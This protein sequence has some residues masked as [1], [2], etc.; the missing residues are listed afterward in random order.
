MRIRLRTAIPSSPAARSRPPTYESWLRSGRGK[1]LQSDDPSTFSFRIGVSEAT[2]ADNIIFYIDFVGRELAC[3]QLYWP[4]LQSRS[5]QGT[6]RARTTHPL[7]TDRSGRRCRCLKKI[8]V[9]HSPTRQSNY[10]VGDPELNDAAARLNSAIQDRL[11]RLPNRSLAIEE[12]AEWIA[13]RNSSCGIFA[14][15]N[16]SSQ[17]VKSIKTCLLKETEERT[18]IL[19]DPNFD[20]LATNT[21]AGMLICSDPSLAT[22]K[23]ELNSHVLGLI[24]KLKGDEAKAAFSEYERWSRERDRSCNL[25][26]KENV[27]LEELSPSESCLAEYL[28]RKTAEIVAAKGDP[29][30]IFG[31]HQFSPLPDADAVDL[32]VAQIHSANACEDFLLVSRVFQI[33]TEVSAQE[34]LVTAEVEMVVLSPFAVCSPIASGCTGR[35]WDLRSGKAKMVF[36]WR[37][38]YGLK[39][40]S[41]SRKP[42]A[43]A[44][45]AIHPR[46]NRSRSGL[47]WAA[48]RGQATTGAVARSGNPF[49]SGNF[50]Q[51]DLV[52]QM[53]R[54]TGM[55]VAFRLAE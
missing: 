22:A 2:M 46:S 39:R 18:A 11:D 30:R 37:T 4:S 21:A 49:A 48:L 28:S 29:K 24:A 52:L 12:N 5:G 3:G 34:A 27:P 47:R 35:C 26:D 6:S 17:D 14:A 13:D 31:Q 50:R 7:P 33:D 1:P 43:A 53:L 38:N 10:F 51:F 8:I 42:T 19:S 32:C 15:Q 20:C 23:T 9:E 40:R 16:I 41:P 55:R 44:G 25:T 45:A 36:R 54:R